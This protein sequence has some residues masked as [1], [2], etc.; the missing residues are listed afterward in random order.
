MSINPH[1]T[2][3]ESAPN[4][5]SAELMQLRTT[6]HQL[7]NATVAAPEE[8]ETF[9]QRSKMKFIASRSA[10]DA[11]SPEERLQ[12]QS[13]AFAALENFFLGQ[14]DLPAGDARFTFQEASNSIIRD[15]K[16]PQFHRDL[17]AY[18][19]QQETEARSTDSKLLKLALQAKEFDAVQIRRTGEPLLKSDETRQAGMDAISEARTT[20]GAMLHEWEVLQDLKSQGRVLYELGY[21]ATITNDYRSAADMQEKSAH[22]TKQMGDKVGAGIARIERCIALLRGKLETPEEIVP[23]LERL[24]EHMRQLDTEVSDPRA[25]EWIANGLVHLSETRE[26]AGDLEGALQCVKDALVPELLKSNI[27]SKLGEYAKKRIPELKE[28]LGIPPEERWVA[29]TE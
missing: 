11:L 7:V 16:N 24:L 13:E 5:S 1:E 22:V 26:A 17:M 18:F 19:I 29:L 12:Y 23:Q 20:L 28:K 21:M 27:G 4:V 6:V 2:L 10:A 14:E 9:K 3:P 25:K 15:T 8:E